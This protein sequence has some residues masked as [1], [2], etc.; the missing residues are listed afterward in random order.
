MTAV[1]RPW[2]ACKS[3]KADIVAGVTFDQ[4]RAT[5]IDYGRELLLTVCCRKGAGDSS[6][7]GQVLGPSPGPSGRR[8]WG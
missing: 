5:A 3:G 4:G 6:A 8:L 2:A 7:V 1:L